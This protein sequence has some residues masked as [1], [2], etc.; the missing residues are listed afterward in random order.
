MLQTGQIRASSAIC[1]V[2][3]GQVAMC[4]QPYPPAHSVITML[5]A[6]NERHIWKTQ[7]AAISSVMGIGLVM[8]AT[9]L[10]LPVVCPLRILTGVPCPLCGMTTGTVAF[11]RGDLAGAAAAN[12][13]SLA[14]LP[15]MLALLIH[16]IRQLV[17]GRRLFPEVTIS[18]AAGRW[19]VAAAGVV[20]VCSW[21]FQLNRFAIL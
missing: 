11:A 15:A 4:L 10:R 7:V 20:L 12:P 18:R 19:V 16:R 13:V 1:D 2:Q 6:F 5:A 17:S 21:L 8:A 14:F 3:F 9:S